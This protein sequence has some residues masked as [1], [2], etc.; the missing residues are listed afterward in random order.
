MEILSGTPH[1]ASISHGTRPGLQLPGPCLLDLDIMPAWSEGCLIGFLPK[2]RDHGSPS[3]RKSDLTLTG[4]GT[5]PLWTYP[6]DRVGPAVPLCRTGTSGVESYCGQ[7]RRAVHIYEV[8][9]EP[10]HINVA[11]IMVHFHQGKA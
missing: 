10:V 4:A 8:R 3:T 2:P 9:V 11:D 5:F 1:A 7:A 6:P